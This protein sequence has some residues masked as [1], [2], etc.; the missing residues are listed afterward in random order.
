MKAI[1]YPEHGGIEVL[2]YTDIP[3]PKPLPNEVLIKVRAT[4]LNHNDLWARRGLQGMKFP[5]PHIPGSDVAGEVIGKGELVTSVEIGQKV[6]IHPAI[7]CRNC[8]ACTSG[9]EYFCR[10]FKI[11][12]FQTGPL[13]GGYAEMIR[14]PEANVIPKP[15]R[16]SW[17]EAATVP[18]CLLTVWHM[19][20]TRAKLQVGQ[21]I[22][23]WGAG[24]GIGSL[25]IQL[26]RSMQCRVITTAS[27]EEKAKKARELGADETVNPHT[28]DVVAAVKK[29]T[30]KKGVEVVFEHTG[31]KTWERSM[32]SLT[33]GGTIVICGNTTGFEAKT[34]LRFLFN[35]QLNLLGSHQGNKAELVEALKLVERGAI[36]PV[37]DSVFPLKDAG[38][39]QQRME[40]SKHFGGLVLVP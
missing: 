32:A 2:K 13:N 6:V 5:L 19:L 28:E 37:V 38:K 12:G 25:A 7:S 31:E 18:L 24:S 34:D 23:V 33:W 17:E 27:S 10:N 8:A 22:L 9:H 11:Y 29:F 3:D 30:N 15:E 16:L 39:A 35:K 20:I 1:I 21:D 36:R 14:I 4:G 26:A 40:E